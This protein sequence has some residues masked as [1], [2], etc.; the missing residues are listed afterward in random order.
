MVV[1]ILEE[2]YGKVTERLDLSPEQAVHIPER[3]GFFAAI[4]SFAEKPVAAAFKILDAEIIARRAFG[5]LFPPPFRRDALRALGAGDFE[6]HPPPP[7]TE[8]RSVGHFGH[9]LDG[10]GAGEKAE[11]TLRRGFNRRFLQSQGR[12]AATGA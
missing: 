3:V 2:L 8:R 9:D 11:R 12:G 6:H 10:F 1:G 5:A 7:E 4:E